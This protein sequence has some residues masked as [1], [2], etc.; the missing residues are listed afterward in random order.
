MVVEF[1]SHDWRDR[2]VRE[3]LLLLLRF[4]V[5]REAADQVAAL[6]L[7]DQLDSLGTGWHRAKPGFFVKISIEVSSAIL[8]LRDGEDNTVLRKHLARIDDPR[9]RRAFRAAVGLRNAPETQAR[10]AEDR[11][12]KQPELW[13]GLSTR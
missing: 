10:R 1:G 9:L 3:W 7:A 12:R 8:A 13:K 11:R 4:A 2:K 5:T 6:A